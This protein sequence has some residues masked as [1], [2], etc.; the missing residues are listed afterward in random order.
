[1]FIPVN[2]SATLD[3]MIQGIV[4]QSGNDA[5]IAVAE[6]M[7]GS[8]ANFAKIMNKEA[9]RLGLANSSFANATGLPH[10]KQLM[11]ARDLAVLSRHLIYTYPEYYKY[12]AQR[13]F[14]YRRW[15][16][17]NRNRLMFQDLGVDGLKTGFTNAAGY[18]VVASAVRNG[19][20]LIAVIGGLRTKKERWAEARRLINWGFDGFARFKVFNA[21]EIVGRARVWGGTSIFVPL[22]G[23]GEVE[24]LLPRYPVNQRLRGEVIYEGPLKPPIRKGDQVAMLRVRSSAGATSQVPL[25]AAEDVERGGLVRR[26]LDSLFHLAFGWIP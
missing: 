20:R 22:I 12:F 15:R 17:I 23:Q 13:E 2:K 7:A 21:D 11:S 18:G 24:V 3:E 5:A 14:K 26:G 9:A 1:M 4:V 6:G 8:E 10:P 25:Y 16:F 19:R